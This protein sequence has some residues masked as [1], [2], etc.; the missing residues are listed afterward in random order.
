MTDQWETYKRNLRAV[1]IFQRMFT[2]MLVVLACM[3]SVAA[4]LQDWA[5]MV[6]FLVLIVACAVGLKKIP[7]VAEVK[8]IPEEWKR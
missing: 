5:P 3:A 4:L 7:P 8:D 1:K 2:G 6:A